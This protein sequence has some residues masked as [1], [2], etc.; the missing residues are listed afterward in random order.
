MGSNPFD[1]MIDDWSFEIA[2]LTSNGTG[3]FYIIRTCDW[4]IQFVSK[5]CPGRTIKISNFY[6]YCRKDSN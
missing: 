2:Q 3:L 4:Y 5:F 6:L 1:V